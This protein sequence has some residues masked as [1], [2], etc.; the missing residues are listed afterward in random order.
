MKPPSFTRLMSIS[1]PSS[2]R[3]PLHVKIGIFSVF[4][5]CM[6][7]NVFLEKLVKIDKSIGALVTFGQFVF[8]SFVGAFTWWGFGKRKNKV[9]MKYHL[10]TVLMF[11]S[12][13]VTNNLAFNYHIP[14]PLHTIFRSGSLVTNMLLGVLIMKKSYSVKKYVSVL[15]LTI[16]IF[17]CTLMSSSSKENTD[18]EGLFMGIALLTYALVM[19]SLIGLLQEKTYKKFGKHPE[20]ALFIDHVIGL[21]AFSYLSS[22]INTSFGNLAATENI[23]PGLPYGVALFMIVA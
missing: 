22:S 23:L 20:E 6:L 1:D 9:P 15:L 13:Q 10:L 21:P 7:N 12:I 8:V 18:N 17:I 2:S 19:S 11:W 5:T 14:M 4:A 16:G 3:T